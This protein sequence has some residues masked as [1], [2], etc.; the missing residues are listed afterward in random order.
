MIRHIS[1]RNFL[2]IETIDLDLTTPITA[3]MGPNEAGKSSLRDAI[4]WAF[5]GEARD[6]IKKEQAALIHDNGTPITAATAEVVITTTEGEFARRKTPKSPATVRGEI[7]SLGLQP[8]ILMDVYAFLTLP[9]GQRRDLVFQVIPGLNP[10]AAQIQERLLQALEE[11]FGI[12]LPLNGLLLGAV[13]NL[14]SLAAS[15]FK[16]AEA[17]AVTKRREAKRLKDAYEEIKAPKQTLNLDDQ[18]YDIPTLNFQAIEATLRELQT[19]KD[20]LLRQKGAAE[21]RVKRLAKIQGQLETMAVIGAVDP[22]E[23][24]RL[25]VELEATKKDLET[26]AEEIRQAAVQNQ[27]FPAICP[28]INLEQIPCPKAGQIVGAE[29][30]APEVLEALTQNRQGLIKKSNEI[31]TALSAAHQQA[32]SCQA[33]AEKKQS[34]QEELARLQA[35]P[36]PGADLDI[37][38]TTREQRLAKGRAFQSAITKY[39]G[40]L[41]RF[42][43]TQTKV[44]VAVQEIEL[45]DLLAKSL[46]PDGI[47]SQLI[48][49]ALDAVNTLLQEAADYLFARHLCLTPELKIVLEGSPFATL[50]KSEK[51]RVGVAFQYALAKLAGAKLMLIDEVDIL[52]F[53]HQV[54]L[55]NFLLA[56]VASEG[57]QV[58]LFETADSPIS[59]NSPEIKIQWLEHGKFQAFKPQGPAIPYKDI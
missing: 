32:D 54:E 56:R 49:E 10:T 47:P 58:L 57:I 45:Y 5:T 44:A 15:S 30:P 21:A 17:E 24:T 33:A 51:F 25:Q 31:N 34:L 28:A 7:P 18:E 43:E 13:G 35:E 4:L 14:S 39:E 53:V 46:A 12:P 48:S 19:Q 27:T 11:K 26:N 38:I 23:I 8:G 22:G 29:P 9:E 52:D 20:G 37:E 6:L 55:S 42:Q 50:S 3:I 41:S 36:D 59:S 1:V 2:A 16:L 40:E